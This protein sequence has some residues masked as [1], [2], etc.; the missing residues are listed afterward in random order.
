[1]RNN[2]PV[3]GREYVLSDGTVII[4]HTDD[5]GRITH[6]NDDFVEVSGFSRDELI[7]QSHNIIRHP[8]MPTEVFRDLWAKIRR[9]SAWEGMIKNRR[10]DGDHYWVKTSVTPRIGGGYMSVRFLA[11]RD[12][13]AAAEALYARMRANPTLRLDGGR[14]ARI[15]HRLTG[16]FGNL[17]LFWKVLLPLAIGMAGIAG[18]VTWQMHMLSTKVLA[19]AGHDSA[20]NMITTA[21]NARIF[22]AGKVLPQALERGLVSSHE[23]ETNP[24]AVPLPASFMRSL[25][26]IS[27]NGSVGR[28]RLYSDLPFAFRKPESNHLDD[29]ERAALAAL[30]QDP[31]AEFARFDEVD[32]ERVYRLAVADRMTEQSCVDCHNSH[33]DSPKRDWKVGDVRG[34]IEATIRIEPI[35]ED[36]QGPV[37]QH[38]VALLVSMILLAAAVWAVVRQSSRRLEDASSLAEAIAGGDL[39]HPLPGDGL[40]EAGRLSNSLA[41]MRNRLYELAASLRQGIGELEHAAADMSQASQVTV[42][43]TD[44][45]TTAAASMASEV[46]HLSNSIREIAANAEENLAIAQETGAAAR[47][48]AEAVH[49]AADEIGNIAQS[50]NQAAGSLTELEGISNEI[51]TIVSSI[52]EIADQTNLLALNAA[53]EAARAGEAGRGFAVV[54]DEVRKLAERTAASTGEISTMVARIQERT[55]GAVQEMRAGVRNVEDG[56]RSAHAAGNAVAAIQDAARRVVDATSEVRQALGVQSTTADE[57]ARNVEQVVRTAEANTGTAT[58]AFNASIRV[59]TMSSTLS[60]LSGQFKLVGDGAKGAAAAAGEGKEEEVDLF[61]L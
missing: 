1:L 32:G 34:V 38:L 2:Q 20:L 10:K 59:S 46:E 48:G 45:Q 56:V 31:K 6:V 49:A 27:G 28:L 43:G 55:V 37:R 13:I 52:R 14:P 21:R 60:S 24:G 51:G 39:T 17:P 8:D 30:R 29:F 18:A 50:V 12:E 7:G 35:A 47:A 33:A 4:S 19:T 5:K 53:I 58:Q 61:N 41:I 36:I 3:T 42:I 16:R 11:G 57:L 54:A 25:G 9:G 40:D 23:F 22:Y 44:Q 26:E 15:S